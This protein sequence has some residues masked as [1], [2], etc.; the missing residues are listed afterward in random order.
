MGFEGLSLRWWGLRG[1]EIYI[2]SEIYINFRGAE[3]YINFRGL[4]ASVVVTVFT[5]DLS[6]GVT[7][8]NLVG[9]T[10]NHRLNEIPKRLSGGD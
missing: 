10:S 8:S 3:I 4:L 6:S 2:N 1:A 9:G 7:S 5:L